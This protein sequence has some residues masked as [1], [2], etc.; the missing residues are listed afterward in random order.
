VCVCIDSFHLYNSKE[1]KVLSLCVNNDD[2]GCDWLLLLLPIL[3][4]Y[5]NGKRIGFKQTI[6]CTHLLFNTK[7][8]PPPPEY[9][10]GN[11]SERTE[12]RETRNE[13]D[14]WMRLC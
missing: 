7:E 6:K 8:P 4:V 3:S 2:D 1:I 10:I 9:K 12:E 13:H 14:V 11:R 5:H